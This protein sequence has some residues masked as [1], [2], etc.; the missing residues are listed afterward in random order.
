MQRHE[1]I[2]NAYH[3]ISEGIII[4]LAV[5]PF[6]YYYYQAVP[7]LV[8]LGV[9]L[10][11][12]LLFSFLSKVSKNHLPFILAWP[13]ILL[14]FYLVG[15]TVS[16]SILF[17]GLLVWRFVVIRSK[18]HLG[19]ESTYL[20]ATF[21]LTLLALLVMRDLQIVVFF[22][23][24]IIVVI[25]GY[26]LSNFVLVT[27]EDRKRMNQSIWLT[28]A[29]FFL[30]ISFF[31]YLF[32]ESAMSI[33]SSLWGG[34]GRGLTFLIS[35]FANLFSFINLELFANRDD[36]IQEDEEEIGFGQPEEILPLEEYNDVSM[37]FYLILSLALLVLFI[38][39]IIYKVMKSNVREKELKQDVHFD[40][41]T[42]KIQI[43]R[44]PRGRFFSRK[45]TRVDHPIRKLVLNFERKAAKLQLGRNQDE[46]IE[47]WFHRV[48]LEGK[49]EVYQKV[50][51]GEMEAT[52][53]EEAMLKNELKQL[54]EQLTYLSRG[55]T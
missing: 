22:F 12:S 30:S 48:G 50:R 42:E 33:A 39:L 37:D 19:F 38:V 45:S 34:I 11:S 6:M 55:L 51:Y 47:N 44:Q 28:V 20:G 9:I 25:F 3:L 21:L 18:A 8:Y 1:T 35:G 16:L 49:I 54:E 17:S 27:K 31:M 4:Y 41:S 5:L 53:E 36:Q 40:K 46:S 2:T 52:I 23:L 43:H 29:G 24:Q 7:E 13:I 32:S 10:G 14:V 15:Y 26:T